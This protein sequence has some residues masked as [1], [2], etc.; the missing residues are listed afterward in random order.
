MEQDANNSQFEK[1]LTPQEVSEWLQIGTK[2]IY[3]YCS[4]SKFSLPHIRIGGNL[5]FRRQ[6]IAAWLEANVKRCA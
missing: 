3:D 1:L 4:R 2:T 6:D 5:R